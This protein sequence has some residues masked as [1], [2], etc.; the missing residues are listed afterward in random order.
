M[1]AVAAS[2]PLPPGQP[3]ALAF[4]KQKPKIA[5][6][7]A[8]IP[9]TPP[10]RNPVSDF[11]KKVLESQNLEDYQILELRAFVADANKNK[12]PKAPV[13][14]IIRASESENSAADIAHLRIAFA[15]VSKTHF[16]ALE[17]VGSQHEMR[18]AMSK[19][20]FDNPATKSRKIETV[21]ILAHG[22]TDFLQFRD[23]IAGKYKTEDVSPLD[24][25]YLPEDATI[26][27]ITCSA[28]QKLAP[29]IAEKAAPRRV[30]APINEIRPRDTIIM[31]CCSKHGVCTSSLDVTSV[32][33]KLLRAMEFSYPK[34]YMLDSGMFQS[35]YQGFAWEN[36][37]VKTF[38]SSC[39]S[40]AS[41]PQKTSP[42]VIE[43]ID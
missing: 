10:K 31:H 9:Y 25:L 12:D 5:Q 22:A 30:Y 6:S 11:V 23:D 1:S 8:L 34:S 4:L 21:L 26:N 32:T 42:A 27:F 35:R 28:G 33:G 39:H 17:I 7:T 40:A 14:L 2:N 20:R 29:V 3:K 36:E 41:P 38:A 24:F 37:V 15:S 16:L 19:T 18:D 43:L 13:A